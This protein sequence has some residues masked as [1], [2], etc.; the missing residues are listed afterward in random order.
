MS[1]PGNLRR[2]V[3]GLPRSSAVGNVGNRRHF[4]AALQVAQSREV[5]T[6][7]YVFSRPVPGMTPTGS[8][9]R[10]LVKQV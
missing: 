9:P 1:I 4:R 10:L 7:P 5:G 3:L 6:V 8:H 2:E